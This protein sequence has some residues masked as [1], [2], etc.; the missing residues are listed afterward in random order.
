M[1]LLISRDTP[2]HIQVIV[3][4]VYFFSVISFGSKPIV[5]VSSLNLT[6][7]IRKHSF[8]M[9]AQKLMAFT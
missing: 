8:A 2:E 9:I 1:I 3:F 4:Y 5:T 7:K 6:K